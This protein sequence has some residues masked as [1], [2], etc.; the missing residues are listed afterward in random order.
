M[1]KERLSPSTTTPNIDLS[2]KNQQSSFAS[3]AEVV[4][5]LEYPVH[6]HAIELVPR[7]QEYRLALFQINDLL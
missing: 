2:Y 6:H 5:T 1:P 4:L 7:T 3:A